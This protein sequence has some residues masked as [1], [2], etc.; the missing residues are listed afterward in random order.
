[1]KYFYQEKGTAH[2]TTPYEDLAV[3]IVERAILDY[4]AA[5]R[6]WNIN[7]RDGELAPMKREC[8]RFFKSKYLNRLTE[9]DG[10]WIMEQIKSV[11]RKEENKQ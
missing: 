4:K 7:G 5:I 3:A 6:D 2:T 8:E 11:V 10:S 1:M 9:L